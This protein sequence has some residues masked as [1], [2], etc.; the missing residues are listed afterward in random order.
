MF[1]NTH[2]VSNS[3]WDLVKI[4]TTLTDRRQQRT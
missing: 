1:I 3:H 4:A 2:G